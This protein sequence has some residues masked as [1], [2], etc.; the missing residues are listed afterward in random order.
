MLESFEVQHDRLIGIPI[1]ASVEEGWV[2]LSPYIV[3][4]KQ[5]YPDQ[6]RTFYVLLLRLKPF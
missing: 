2:L 4:R 5:V 3:L 1:P 6:P